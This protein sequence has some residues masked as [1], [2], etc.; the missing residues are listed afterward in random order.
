[1]SSI[2]KIDKKRL[3]EDS[4][5]K[6]IKE[7]DNFPGTYMAGNELFYKIRQKQ[8]SC[9][10]LTNN[11]FSLLEFI[12]DILL[13]IK[14]NNNK[15]GELSLN[16]IDF[17]SF[18]ILFIHNS[19]N[20]MSFYWIIRKQYSF[21]SSVKV[22]KNEELIDE[23]YIEDEAVHIEEENKR[24]TKYLNDDKNVKNKI[25]DD[26][27]LKNDKMSVAKMSSR[28]STFDE[29]ELINNINN[30]NNKVEDDSSN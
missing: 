13:K 22:I 1:M 19:T 24:I 14:Y 11:L 8:Y 12:F 30:L 27:S 17:F 26:L 21:S 25:S 29:N 20:F 16:Y 18:F 2:F 23:K 3:K 15:M 28:N 5:Q 7:K 9:L 6:N 4:E 10:Y